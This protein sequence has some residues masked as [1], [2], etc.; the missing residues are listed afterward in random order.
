MEVIVI[1]DI[2]PLASWILAV[3]RDTNTDM[4]R[5]RLAMESAGSLLA[6]HMAASLE[7]EQKSVLTPLGHIAL[8]YVPKEKPVVIG[9]LGASLPLVNGFCRVFPDCSIGFIAARRVEEP[10]KVDVTVFYER[11]PRALA[12]TVIILDPMIATGST[13]KA[14]IRLLDMRGVDRIIVGSAITSRHGVETLKEVERRARARID[15]YTLA[16][17]P[18]L[19][20]RFFIVPGL[21]DA[22]DRALG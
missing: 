1:R 11:L 9:I 6:T 19:D 10:G 22:G 7:W 14:S 8:E 4:S 3:L 2:N 5:F 18:E 21:G 15:L 12:R 16:L 20:N 13:M 17:D